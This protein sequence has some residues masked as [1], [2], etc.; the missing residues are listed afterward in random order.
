MD[1]LVLSLLAPKLKEKFENSN[2]TASSTP[3]QNTNTDMNKKFNWVNFIISAVI[4][5]FAAY[6]SWKCNT[7]TET[8]II[9]KVI[10]AIFAFLFGLFYLILYFIF[11]WGDCKYIREKMP[12]SQ[13][14]S[15]VSYE[16]VAPKGGRK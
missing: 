5:G 6:L 13:S 9:L 14:T 1:V 4:G 10:F 12:K 3:P 11:R 7:L 8:N 2:D 16:P 15:V